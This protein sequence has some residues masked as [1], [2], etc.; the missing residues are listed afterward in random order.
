MI[1]SEFPPYSAGIGNAA[2]HLSKSLIKK[3]HKV[4]VITRGSWIRKKVRKFEGIT[5]Y[6][7][8]FIPFFPP[9][10][11]LYHGYFVNN[12]ISKIQKDFDILHLHS[13]LIPIISADIP[14]VIMVHSTWHAEAI[15]FEKVT[16]W[17]SLA[18]KV[19][20]KS[21]INY[22][23]KLFSKSN[24]FIAIS[25]G[26]AKELT[27]AYTINKDKI[28]IVQN[29]ID[30]EK[31]KALRKKTN[32]SVNKILTI[33]R[34]VYRKGLLDLVDAAK[35]V[36][37]ENP[38]TLFTI[39]GKGPL[40]KVL[41]NKIR[42]YHL[43]NNVVM[44]GEVPHAE[45]KKYLQEANVF[46]IPSHYEGL[47]LSLLEAI[48][49][50]KAIVGTDIKGIRDIITNGKNG[51]LVPKSNPKALARAITRIIINVPLQKKLEE[52]AEKSAQNFDRR[53]KT[54]EILTIYNK[55]LGGYYAN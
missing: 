13:P 1:S 51:L 16:D 31:Y 44:P 19:F 28:H 43:E 7:M 49:S 42:E 45:I 17:Y 25:N 6:E 11:I 12:L 54:E 26:M 52:N 9:F 40:E 8:P 27:H 18:V 46:V 3:G 23:K 55:L 22:E 29:S 14:N 36:C 41:K 48:A 32:N 10:H 33:N 30:I 5:V 37:R 2:Y 38:Q 50:G 39:I 35:I 24:T 53:K 4:T 21:F 47:P 20:K 34:L 15:A